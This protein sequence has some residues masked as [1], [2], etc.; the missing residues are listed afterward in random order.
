MDEMVILRLDWLVLGYGRILV[1]SGIHHSTL[2]VHAS[3]SQHFFFASIKL[4]D[5]QD[6][7]TRALKLRIIPSEAPP[8]VSTRQHRSAV[9]YDYPFRGFTQL[10]PRAR[11][12]A[13]GPTIH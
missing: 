6:L 12:T 11:F 5:V 3:D 8:Y 1:T 13:Y 10:P 2:F 9:T 7:E 4:E